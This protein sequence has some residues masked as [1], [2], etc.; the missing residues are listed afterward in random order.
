M[1]ITKAFIIKIL[2]GLMLFFMCIAVS[3][4]SFGKGLAGN[5]E[6]NIFLYYL[7]FMFL[8][9]FAN[10]NHRNLRFALP[11]PSIVIFFLL[12]IFTSL[13]GYM[14]YGFNGMLLSMVFGFIEIVALE[15]SIN[16]LSYNEWLKLI[17]IILISVIIVV[18]INVLLQLKEIIQALTN[19]FYHP[20]I[21][22]VFIGGVNIESSWLGL[23]SV[24][25]LGKKRGIL[26]YINCVLLSVIYVSRAGIVSNALAFLWFFITTQQHSTKK[27]MSVAIAIV[28]LSVVLYYMFDV[29]ETLFGRLTVSGIVEAQGSRGRTRIWE[30][31]IPMIM[32]NPLGY[33]AGNA[34][35]AI[36]AYAGI[37]IYESNMHNIFMQ[38]LVDEGIVGFF[39]L[40]ILVIG[41]IKNEI[42]SRLRSPFAAALTIYLVLSLFQFRGCEALLFFILSFYLHYDRKTNVKT[43]GYLYQ[44][45]KSVMNN[46]GVYY[47]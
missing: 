40:F 2:V 35:K 1:R 3:I 15:S 41:F 29:V 20:S 25:F 27:K 39:S 22:T 46:I 32:N 43:I 31:V 8:I 7:I 5:A 34:I 4:Y 18:D 9:P 23:F 12:N 14:R 36:S 45:S 21:T 6:Q 28:L 42:K 37:T 33:G 13:V 17:R 38:Y 44:T 19:G 11:E 16:Y 47:T 10:R 24:F 26:F 30:H